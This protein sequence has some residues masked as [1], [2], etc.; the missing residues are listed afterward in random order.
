MEYFLEEK[1]FK[2]GTV[3]KLARPDRHYHIGPSNPA[4][5]S[6]Y[7]CKGVIVK[8]AG[9]GTCY[10]DWENGHQ[11]NYKEGELCYFN[12]KAGKLISIWD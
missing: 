4:V 11:N 8:T 10:V 1:D 2:I 7:E 9:A 3:V 12:N 5:G 6:K